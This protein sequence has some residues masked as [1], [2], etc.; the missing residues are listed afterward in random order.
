MDSAAEQ[1]IVAGIV[2][3]PTVGD[4]TDK[5][6]PRSAA[7]PQVIEKFDNLAGLHQLQQHTASTRRM[8]KDV[9]MPAR[10][11]PDLFR[12]QADTVLL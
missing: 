4:A 12:N 6:A 1:K 8:Y 11:S 2:D 7:S 3:L 5:C 9:L 10:P